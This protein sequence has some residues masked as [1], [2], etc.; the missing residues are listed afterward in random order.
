MT[1]R[2]IRRFDAASLGG[3]FRHGM[4]PAG[5]VELHVVR[6][7]NGDPLVLLA[8]WPQSWYAWRK[9]MPRLAARYAVY[10]IDLPGMGDSQRPAAGYDVAAVARRVRHAISAL[11]IERC[12]L[13]THDIGTWVA[14]PFAHEYGA[15]VRKVVLMD[16][17]IPGLYAPPPDPKLWHFGFNQQRGLAEALTEGRERVFLSWFFRNRSLVT[18]A[19]SEADLDEYERVYSAPGAMQAGFEY[20]RAMPVSA[21]Q[22]RACAAR[23]RLAMPVAVFGSDTAL[24]TA[25]IEAM[26]ALADDLLAEI[27]PGSGHY[28]PEEKPDHL[29]ERLTGFLPR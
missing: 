12:L 11:G 8:G 3:G 19:I 25:M 24:G 13:V 6:G 15:V 21:E 9:V 26:R 29:L 22:N 2:S 1:A 18:D 20:Y 4:V 14:F 7:G 27:V 28:I 17:A 10:A 5:D 23:G 16:A